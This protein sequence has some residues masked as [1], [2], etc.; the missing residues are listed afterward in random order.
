LLLPDPVDAFWVATAVGF[1]GK[2]FKSVT[3]GAADIKS[4]PLKEKQEAGAAGAESTAAGLATLYALMKQ[5]L[6]EA[7]EDV[8]ASDRLSASPACL[9]ASDRGPDRRLE[10]MLAETGRLGPATKPVL[11][12]NPAHPLIRAL[13]ARMGAPDKAKFEDIVWLLFDEARLMEGEKPADAPHFAARLTRILLDAAG[14][15]SP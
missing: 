11:E 6:G 9:V 3:Q 4:I 1:D 13:A 7:V 14:Q 10:R 5:V 15:P 12:I 2:Q 8:R